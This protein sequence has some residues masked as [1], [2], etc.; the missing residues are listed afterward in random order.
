MSKIQEQATKNPTPDQ[1]NGDVQVPEEE[2]VGKRILNTVINVILVIAIALA[3]LCTYT[4]YVASSGNGVPSVLGVRMFSIQT[5]SM[6]PTLLPGDLIFD[7]AVK[8]A[9]ELRPGDIITYWTVING[10]RVLNTHRIEQVYDGGGYLIF[11]TKGDNNTTADPL[12][13][14]ESEVVGKYSF[15]VQGLGKVFDYL[16][17]STGF[18]IVVVVPVFLFFL[19]HLVQFFRVLFEYQNVKNRIKYEQERGRTEDLIEDQKR[20]QAEAQAAARAKMEAELRE[21]LRAEILA[22]MGGQKPAEPAPAEEKPAEAPAPA[23]EKPAEAPAPAEEKPAEPA[24]AEEKPAE[25]APAE[26]KPAEAPTPAEEKPAEAPAPAEEKPAE[27]PAP[28]EEKPAEPAPAEEKPAEP[29]PAEEKPA[30]PAPAEE[31]PAEPA[32]AEEKP[33]VPVMDEAAIEA[34]IAKQRAAIEAQLR[35]KIMAEMMA[36]MNKAP[37]ADPAAAAENAEGASNE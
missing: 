28:A 20:A 12:T 15:R 23:E 7:M 21:R 32:P 36:N 37:A 1:D 16:Q 22:S 18:L 35:E 24:P 10:E 33:A 13:V 4:S 27:A 29:A 14:H 2:S 26:E 9:G 25:P 31:K 5:E 34:M 30:E 3:A 8:D 19:F 17:T 11:S 6:Y